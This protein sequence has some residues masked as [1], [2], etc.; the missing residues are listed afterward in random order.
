MFPEIREKFFSRE[1]MKI[2]NL[3]VRKFYF[4]KYEKTFFWENTIN[5]LRVSFLG[6]NIRNV[7]MGK[8]RGLGLET[9]IGSSVYNY[10]KYIQ[11]KSM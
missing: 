5:F 2:F 10:W 6:K 9:A 7:F 4:P 11:E 8:F 3:G 1:H